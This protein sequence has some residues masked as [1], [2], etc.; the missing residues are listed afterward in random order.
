MAKKESN[1]KEL[2]FE[3]ALERLET[4]VE[5]MESGELG[6]DSMIAAFEEGQKLVQLC[7]TRLNEVERKIEKIVS[8]GNEPVVRTEPMEVED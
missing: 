5:Q 3:A 8:N 7:T 2:G 6:I 4:L 1:G